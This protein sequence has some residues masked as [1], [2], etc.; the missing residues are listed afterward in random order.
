VGAF[1]EGFSDA[2]AA[3]DHHRVSRRIVTSWR[4]RVFDV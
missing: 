1:G 3:D 4:L 2:L